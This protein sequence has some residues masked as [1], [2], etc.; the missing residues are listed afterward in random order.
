LSDVPAL[1]APT[2]VTL[3]N[4]SSLK[5]DVVLH[6]QLSYRDGET[7]IRFAHAIRSGRQGVEDSITGPAAWPAETLQRLHD[8]CRRPI[9][10]DTG[11]V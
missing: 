1:E 4:Y 2:G 3:T 9:V 5:G 7:A 11:R 10:T 8:E 6:G